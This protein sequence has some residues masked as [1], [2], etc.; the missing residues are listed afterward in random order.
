MQ[1]ISNSS[2]KQYSSFKSKLKMYVT[3]P[4]SLYRKDPSAA[5]LPPP[6]GPNSGILVI[7][8]P[9]SQPTSCFGLINNSQ[10]QNLPFPQS[11]NLEV[12]YS[13]Q[14]AQNTQIEINYLV[15]IPAVGQPLS[16]NRYY[17]IKRHGKHKGEAYTN[18]KEEEMTT[19]CFCKCIKDKKSEAFKPEGHDIYQQF[20]ISVNKTLLGNDGYNAKSVAED[21]FPPTFLRRD[22]WYLH[23]STPRQF[24]LREALGLDSKLR[25]RLP[26]FTDDHKP[27]V[28]GKWYCPFLFI[29]DSDKKVQDQVIY[30]RFYEMTLEQQWEPIF[31]CDH[32]GGSHVNVDVDVETEGVRVGDAMG[33][34]GG[35]DGDG[36]V[37]FR[38]GEKNVGLSKLI[39]ERMEWEEERVGW[40]K[41][42]GV[43]RVKKVEEFKG[44]R[45]TWKR[46][47][48]FVL[49]ERFVLRRMDGSFVMSYE[50]KHL[51]QFRIKWE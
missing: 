23:T 40:R 33:K 22:G 48:Y 17:I 2:T 10:V 34:N 16:A 38:S 25:A 27:T 46:F 19:C 5:S 51:H 4:L 35:V 41:K 20:Q 8:D 31:S 26:D 44:G 13:Y 39:V 30:S 15:F 42:N 29:K 49:I 6:E 37:W 1:S 32:A 43:V 11:K 36:V 9:E 28:V 18:S 7:Q 3:R 45:G 24:E 14:V 47:G 21:G 50:F 12:R